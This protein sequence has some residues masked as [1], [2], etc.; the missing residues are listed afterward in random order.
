MQLLALG[1]G[2]RRGGD[3]SGD[4]FMAFSTANPGPVPQFAPAV[5]SKQELNGEH[6][7]PLYLASVQAV[8][9]A[10]VNAMVAGEDVATFKPAGYVCRALDTDR[11]RAIFHPA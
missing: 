5:L 6:I 10:I 3:N 2:A 4:I 7:D 1:G 8:E 9:E 11:L